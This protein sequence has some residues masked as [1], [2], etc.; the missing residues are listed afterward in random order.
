MLENPY[1]WKAEGEGD[2]AHVRLRRVIRL[3][4]D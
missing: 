1:T 2:P 3:A 4:D